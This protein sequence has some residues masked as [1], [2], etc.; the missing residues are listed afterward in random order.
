MYGHFVTADFRELESQG[1][2][3]VGAERSN[4]WTNVVKYIF[5]A[6]VMDFL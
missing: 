1:L 6:E 4:A 5:L 2:A 3:G